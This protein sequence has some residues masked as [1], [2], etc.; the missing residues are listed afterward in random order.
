MFH[1]KEVPS[2]GFESNQSVLRLEGKLC[3]PGKR[4]ESPFWRLKTHFERGAKVS[5][6]Y[7]ASCIKILDQAEIN[8][9]W[10]WA[11]AARLAEQYKRPQAWIERGLRACE[12]AG[13][14]P[15]YFLDRYLK[16]LPIPRNE[17]VEAAYRE[18]R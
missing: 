13:V 2:T 6:D 8:R 7:N 14:D 16:R 5:G 1:N 9:R 18:L 17:A 3:F 4:L 11:N 10:N 15:A 12:A